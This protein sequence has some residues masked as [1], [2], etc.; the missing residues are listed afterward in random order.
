MS[1]ICV[2][3]AGIEGQE[4]FSQRALELIEK[5]DLLVG[6]APQLALFPTFAGET[7]MIDNN[8][9]QII[10]RLKS[11]PPASVVLASGD[12]LFF[13]SGRELLRNL[14]KDRLSFVPNISSVQYAFAKIGEPW[15]DAIS[16]STSGRSL[17]STIDRIVAN[18]KAA[19]L[20][21]MDT[22]PAAIAREI[23]ERGRGG[24][25]AW[26]CENLGLPDEQ[27]RELTLQQ[28]LEI[29]AAPLNILVLV[30]Q[31]EKRAEEVK[32]TFGI[33][34]DQFASIRGTITHEEVR[35]ITLAKL[36]LRHDHC[37]WDIGAGSGSVSIEADHLL[38]NGRIL[39]VERDAES[40]RHLKQNLNSFN[41]RNITVI[42][43]EAPDCL[44]NLPDP[45][46]VFIG[47]SGGNLW[48]ILD[49]VDNRLPAEGRIVLNATT[50]D[51]LNTANEWFDNAGY[52][53]EVSTVNI[54]RTCSDSDY[55]MF[56]ALPPVYVLTGVKP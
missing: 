47:G 45:D 11:A 43:A 32:P 46:R 36:R 44:E 37:L 1:R 7:L 53:L 29:N 15:D 24:Y 22:P 27:I 51:T 48:D 55:K 6:R 56:D 2:I 19:V 38:S 4:G 35:V 52:A 18:D 5:A 20:T 26:L 25:K 10:E 17:Q 13:G 54:A 9:P 41:A 23:L 40:A 12:P 42:E 30:K 39:A 31:Y 34:D 3:G 21:D 16:I 28:L 8:W 50:L 14:P 49:A 33:P